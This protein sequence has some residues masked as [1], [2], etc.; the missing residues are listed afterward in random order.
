MSETKSEAR[1]VLSAELQRMVIERSHDL[2][3][4]IETDGTIVYASPRWSTML[5]WDP[6]EVVGTSLLDYCHP[7]D[8][9]QGAAA[10]EQFAAGADL[11]S[12]VTRR[13]TKDGR[14]L[15][16]ESNA[17]PIFDAQGNV[18]HILGSARDVTEREE[19][20]IGL[21]EIDALFRIA[22]A[23][24]RSTSLA[25]LFDEAIDIL[26]SVTSADRASILLFDAA[27]V[28]RFV[29]WRDLS[30]GYRAATDGHTPWRPDT[31]DPEP[32]LVPDVATAGFDE[33][34]EAAV[35]SEG[36]AALAFIPLALGDRL[37]GKFMLY[38]RDAGAWGDR[39]IRL[40]RTIANH[41]A[42]ATVR[43]RVR[44]ELRASREQLETIM[45]TVDEGIVVQTHENQ[46]V[47][48]NDGAARVIGFAN[49]A[50]FI[51]SER[52]EVL[53]RFEMLRQDGTPLP[54]D[55]L[56]GRRALRGE[57]AEEVIRY[58][59]KA[60]GE[61]RWSIVRARPVLGPNGEIVASVSVIH[62]VTQARTADLAARESAALID[63][64]FRNAPVGLAFWDTNLNYVRVNDELMEMNGL[65]ASEM[66]G[67]NV[68]E[69]FPLFEQQL[70]DALQRALAGEPVLGLE[71]VGETPAEPGL[72][73]VWSTSFYPVHDAAGTLLGVGGIIDEITTERRSSE[74]I[75][76]L[77]R[78]SEMLNETLDVEHTLA[79]LASVAVPA[80]A[81]H[82]TVDLFQDGVLRCVGARHVDP[83][84]T[85]LMTRL[86]EQYPPTVDSHP[87]QRAL[88]SGEPQFVSDVQAEA[89]AMAHDE[90][91]AAAIH[92]LGNESGIVVPLKA[93]GRTFGAITFG[94]VPPQPRFTESDL[95][96]AVEL[97]RRASVALDNSLLFAEAEGRARASEALE[98][99]DDGV[100][101]VDRDEIVRLL[102]PA[103]ARSFSVKPT[104]AIGR[105]IDEVVPD[106]QTVRDRVFTAPDLAPKSRRAEMLP[107]EIKGSERWLS[108][109]AARF[110]GGT[111]YAFR[112]M[113]EE[114]AVEQL[115]SD[116][117]STVSHEL[118]T[119]LAAIYGAA[120]T[121]QRDDV[122]LEDSQRSGLLDVI[123]SEADR[124]ARIVNDILWASRLDSGQMAIAIERCDAAALTSLVVDAVRTHV[125]ANVSVVLESPEGLPPVAA[126][127]DKL[128]QVLTNLVDNAVK[129]S[130]DG[131]RVRVALSHVGSRIRFRVED[132][133][134]GI[135]PAE[136]SRIFE[137]FFRLDPNLT[138]GVGGTGLGLY[139]CRELVHRMHGRIWV[140]SDGRRGST[141]TVELPAAT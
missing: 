91:H 43:T 70:R 117:V 58:R 99:V 132:Q 76:F 33:H 140:V 59:V 130:P 40:C 136:Q 31:R 102:N 108:I 105:R 96:L 111:V 1:A 119:P 23:I 37:L 47:Y 13:A 68:F 45:R 95:E 81:G 64:V 54:P 133:G 97:G 52:E 83:A 107:I 24:A 9:A 46:I 61:E 67:R 32:V 10:I 82:V 123:S 38:R 60:T 110:A 42:S 71:V 72:E 16:V 131:G 124:L 139:I 57:T 39:E 74:R 8:L 77:A 112:D 116:F 7:D 75:R 53:S 30:N 85:E 17:T 94:T 62:D 125:P 66:L 56:P 20:R 88:A 127:P 63:G 3:T 113:T 2:V 79:A 28:M 134:L 11:P 25:E 35:R 118:R 78:A 89:D 34:L 73:R 138:R 126:D 14:W 135:P 19:L 48:A 69:V 21:A 92:D 93:R 121:L 29:A 141:F 65:E 101:L 5:G 115:K 128:R 86:R 90:T 27:N 106:W 41:L 26:V 50:E 120:L 49:A 100:L 51:G 109:S 98:F 18:T 22:D 104:K 4:L 55:E 44:E 114:R 103:A 87:V 15:N 80:F 137:K 12:V 84:K 122:R 36:I 129:Y 6:E